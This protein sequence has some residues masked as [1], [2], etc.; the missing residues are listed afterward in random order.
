MRDDPFIGACPA[1]CPWCGQSIRLNVP[2]NVNA[3]IDECP[4][5]G[6][7]LSCSR[8]TGKVTVKAYTLGQE[9]KA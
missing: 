2:E 6:E 4:K 9:K 5:C 3:S 7:Y 8:G 1:V